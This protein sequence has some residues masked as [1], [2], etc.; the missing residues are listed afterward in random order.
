MNVLSYN[1]INDFKD[2]YGVKYTN[3][4]HDQALSLLTTVTLRV[5]TEVG[6]SWTESSDIPDELRHLIIQVAARYWANPRGVVQESAGPYSA[7]YSEQAAAGIYFT[8]TERQ[9]LARYRPRPTGIGT[10]STT[11]GDYSSSQNLWHTL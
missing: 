1:L 6:S 7:R 5:Q 3:D 8:K 10:I 4:Q 11:R 2:W 9:I